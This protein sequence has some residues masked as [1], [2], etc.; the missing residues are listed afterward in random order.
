MVRSEEEQLVVHEL[1]KVQSNLRV[2]SVPPLSSS[3]NEAMIV[4]LEYNQSLCT[5]EV[6]NQI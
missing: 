4:H 6:L 3:N 1:F 5:K 2:A